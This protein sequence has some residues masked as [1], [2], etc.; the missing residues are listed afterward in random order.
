MMACGNILVLQN[1][2]DYSLWYQHEKKENQVVVKKTDNATHI[3]WTL[4][5]LEPFTNY[6][7]YVMAY[8]GIGGSYYSNFATAM[9]LQDGTNNL[10]SQIYLSLCFTVSF[11]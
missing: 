6:T 11:E 1:S 3:S 10:T 4:E 8:N 2:A 9:T 5:S 7:F